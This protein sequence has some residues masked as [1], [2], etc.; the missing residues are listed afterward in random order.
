MIVSTRHEGTSEKVKKI[1]SRA[2]DIISVHLI[3]ILTP[4][5]DAGAAMRSIANA[6]GGL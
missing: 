1:L 6:A 5:K 2:L 3:K 4:A